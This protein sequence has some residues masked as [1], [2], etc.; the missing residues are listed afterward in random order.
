MP[1]QRNADINSK[2]NW[3]ANCC[4]LMVLQNNAFNVNV[5]CAVSIV[6]GLWVQFVPANRLTACKG[7]PI[8]E[9]NH[10]GTGTEQTHF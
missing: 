10:R 6:P 3:Y 9:Y 8:L 2:S 7:I 5:V 4:D 1:M